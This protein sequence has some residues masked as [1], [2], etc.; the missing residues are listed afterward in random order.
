MESEP[1]PNAKAGEL[2]VFFVRRDTVCGDCGRELHHGAMI[3]LEKKK[4]A[5]CLECA[6][7]DH[8]DYLPSGNAALT[9]RASKHSGL[10]AIVLE[11]S[12]T[13]QRYERQGVLVE[14]EALERAER[15]C[16]N[17]EEHRA[18]P[19]H[20]HEGR[21]RTR[22]RI[23]RSRRAV[24]LGDPGARHEPAHRVPAE[25]HDHGWIQDLK[26]AKQVPGARRDLVR[27]RVTVVRRAALDDV[28]D[29]NVLA[30]PAD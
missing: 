23:D 10:R 21:S 25:G 17:D 5:L 11:W 3:T 8:L 13:R 15:E 12:R 26:L 18:P 6:D 9:R 29:E 20:S 28:G 30:P 22:G 7:L 1:P 24:G 19:I 4:G 27:L 14:P 2:L 16:Q